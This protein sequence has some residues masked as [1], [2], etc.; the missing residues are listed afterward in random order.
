MSSYSRLLT[1]VFA[2]TLSACCANGAVFGSAAPEGAQNDPDDG[3]TPNSAIEPITRH[4]DTDGL[5]SDMYYFLGL[6]FAVVGVLYVMPESVTNWD[7]ETKS[8][9]QFEEWLKH[10]KK[11]KWDKDGH[12]INYLLHP[13]WG[14]T[15][16]VR[17]RERGYGKAG[18]FWYSVL[19]STL[20]EYGLESVFEHPSKQDLFVTPVIGSWLG[21]HFMNWREKTKKRIAT[22]GQRRLRDRA[23]IGLTDPLGAVRGWI[24]HKLDLDS[25]SLMPFTQK[26]APQD[27]L[28]GKRV[29]KMYGLHVRMTF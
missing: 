18:S 17:A 21:V 6:Q 14:A 7:E 2:L 19:L 10:V 16:Y 29:N 5:R 27:N 24:D 13:Y 3:I 23:L 15:Y 28:R 12:V 9:A 1:L 25:V 22:T 11:A 4:K 8:Q 26:R 20:Y